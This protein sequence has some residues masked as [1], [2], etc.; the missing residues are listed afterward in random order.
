MTV[1]ELCKRAGIT[2]Q[3]LNKQV[4]FGE[5]PGCHRKANERLEIS[6]CRELDE[7][8]QITSNRQKK[9]R[10]KRLSLQQRLDRIDRSEITA[11]YTATELGRKL[12]VTAS[13]INRR[14]L[15]IP[16]ADFDGRRYR[17]RN[18]PEMAQWIETEIRT[19]LQ[20][21]ESEYRNRLKRESFGFPKA[22]FLR[23]GA[24]ISKAVVEFNR[25]TKGSPIKLWGTP[26]LR[27][28]K[29]DLAQ[30]ARI[31]LDVDKELLRRK[32]LSTRS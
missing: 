31:A 21:K 29:E 14:V 24:A 15:E 28:F 23:A 2:R 13:T 32:E 7:W 11:S 10:G 25:A 1:N 27:S 6:E 16:G 26:E 9:K 4:D 8:V 17:F 30:F 18:T 5:V 12:G 20:E 22:P 19:R 3:W